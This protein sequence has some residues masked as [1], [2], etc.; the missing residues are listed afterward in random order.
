LDAV[1]SG[2]PAVTVDASVARRVVH[3][4]AVPHRS[5]VSLAFVRIKDADDRLIA[6]GRPQDGSVKIDRVLVDAET[7]Q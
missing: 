5:D 7:Y 1:L 4:V 3:G 6:I 2:L